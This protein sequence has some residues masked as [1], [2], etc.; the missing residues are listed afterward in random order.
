MHADL[1]FP[2]PTKPLSINNGGHWA[3]KR[4]L[5]DP[6]K[7]AA[8][9]T[10][11]NHLALST[12]PFTAAPPPIPVTVQAVIPFRGHRRR[13]PH[14][15]TGTVVK[16]IVDGL[17]RAGVVPDDTARW[18]TVIDSQL[19]I[20]PAPKPLTAIIRIRPRETP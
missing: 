14:N 1:E 19:A 2:A 3:K 6:W 13:D 4:R 12:P 17:V 5:L 9:V 16:A 11:R 7:D 10:A 18:V 8:W 20:I 15:Y